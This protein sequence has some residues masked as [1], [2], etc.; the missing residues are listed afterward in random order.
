MISKKKRAELYESIHSDIMD[1]RIKIA[2]ITN[3][4]KAGNEVYDLLYKFHIDCP[5]KAIRIFETK[6]KA[7]RK[8]NK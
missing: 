3:G 1:I 5:E 2:R 6:S 7:A 4:T 8:K